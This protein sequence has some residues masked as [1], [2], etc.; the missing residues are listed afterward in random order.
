MS[1]FLDDFCVIGRFGM[2]SRVLSACGAVLLLGA[3]GCFS[4]LV[5]RDCGD[6]SGC[7]SGERC[8]A[9]LCTP[10]ILGDGV[11]VGGEEDVAEPLSVRV[12]VFT[13]E[14]RA[15]PRDNARSALS[16]Q[17]D[18]CNCTPSINVACV[19]EGLDAAATHTF[20]AS[21]NGFETCKRDLSAP[22]GGAQRL[23]LVMARCPEENPACSRPMD[24]C[25]CDD[26][27]EC[28]Q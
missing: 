26:F 2:A 13:E 10:V 3:S 4:D 27:A 23:A 22:Q 21:L 5:D 11:D 28:P 16:G 8:I 1:L 17:A 7:F 19:Y 18:L 9:G 20:C 14:D 15:T 25:V 6:D 24:G 12:E